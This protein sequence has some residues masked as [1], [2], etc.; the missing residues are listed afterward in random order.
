[1]NGECSKLNYRS[2]I[3]AKYKFKLITEDQ[4]ITHLMSHYQLLDACSEG[5]FNCNVTDP[6]TLSCISDNFK[7]DGIDHCGNMNDEKGCPSNT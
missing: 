7:C 3:L 2:N 6:N 1:M 4:G 5:L